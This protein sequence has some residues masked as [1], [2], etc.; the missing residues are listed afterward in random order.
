MYR[1]AAPAQLSLEANSPTR[2][3]AQR[4]LTGQS[5]E[6]VILRNELNN[7]GLLEVPLF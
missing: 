1:G 5:I 3:C 4:T 6:N 2:E 7:G